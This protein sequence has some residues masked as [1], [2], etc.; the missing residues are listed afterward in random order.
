MFIHLIEAEDVISQL[1][2]SSKMN[3]SWRFLMHLF[4]IGR[5]RA[6]KWLAANFDDVGSKSTVDLEAKYV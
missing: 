2:G 1:A 6:D 3:A 4:D 5:Q